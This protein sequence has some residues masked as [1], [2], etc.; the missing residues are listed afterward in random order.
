MLAGGRRP[1]RPFGHVADLGDARPALGLLADGHAVADRLL[2]GLHEIEEA[3][4]GIDDDGPG[5]FFA[6][7]LDD[8][9]LI[10]LR[11]Q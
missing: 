4:I 8:V 11:D 9:P 7:I 1:G 3:R 2:A 10:V 6:V 5:R